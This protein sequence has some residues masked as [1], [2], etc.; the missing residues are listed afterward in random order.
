MTMY[1]ANFN[2]P[3]APQ[4]VLQFKM[5]LINANL[6]QQCQPNW[7]FNSHE[8]RCASIYQEPHFPHTLRFAAPFHKR[9]IGITTSS[10]QSI[11]N[12]IYRHQI[13]ATRR[14]GRISISPPFSSWKPKTVADDWH[15]RVRRQWNRINH[16][17]VYRIHDVWARSA[18]KSHQQEAIS[19]RPDYPRHMHEETMWGVFVNFA[20]PERLIER[21]GITRAGNDALVLGPDSIRIHFWESFGKTFSYV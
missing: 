4:Q 5:L 18:T 8:R 2:H 12:V 1:S 11:Q 10:G 16:R 13:R 17:R 6:R 14:S 19:P 20:V 9:D 7:I 3:L 15:F 21:H